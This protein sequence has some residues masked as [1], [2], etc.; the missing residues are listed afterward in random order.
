[1]CCT[2][3]CSSPLHHSHTPPQHLRLLKPMLK[4]LLPQFL[5]NLYTE[6]YLTL[7][8]CTMFCVIQAQSNKLFTYRTHT[9]GLFPTTLCMRNDTLHL[10]T[11]WKS[12]IGVSA[13]TCMHKRMNAPLN[14]L[15]TR[16]LRIILFIT[17]RCSIIQ[18]K[19]KFLH[20]MSMFL[21]FIAGI[22]QIKILK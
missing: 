18:I 21:C 8:L 16:F 20:F 7:V 17:C 19:T 5:F 22:T 15:S 6:W 10:L 3:S 4:L 11:T 9:V 14:R 2:R 13:L 12:T 1:M